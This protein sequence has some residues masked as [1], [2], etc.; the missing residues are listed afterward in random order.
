MS[1]T[2]TIN[3]PI[4]TQLF[5]ELSNFLKDSGSTADPV[6]TVS[7]AIKYWLENAA[8]KPELISGSNLKGYLWKDVFLPH[9][10]VLRMKYKDKWHY[11]CV[12]ED[13]I[14]YNETAVSPSEFANK[15]TNTSRNAW[16]DIY[17][18]RPSDKEWV[19]ADTLRSKD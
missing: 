19:F 13:K 3:I 15:V 2:S 14:L 5:L 7:T 9:D 18:K 1:T 11:A 10:T 6:H 8:W 16:R 4:P 17:I 12:N